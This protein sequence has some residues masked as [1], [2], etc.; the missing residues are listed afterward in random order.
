[1]VAR[2]RQVCVQGCERSAGE[3]PMF[4]NPPYLGGESHR[5]AAMPHVREHESQGQRAEESRCRCDDPCRT[6]WHGY[7]HQDTPDDEHSR[8]RA[9]A[10]ERRLAVPERDHCDHPGHRVC[11]PHSRVGVSGDVAQFG[12]AV[13]VRCCCRRP[14]AAEHRMEEHL[15]RSNAYAQTPQRYGFSRQYRADCSRDEQRDRDT[16]KR[17]C[18]SA[19]QHVG[20]C[21]N[22]D[23]ERCGGPA[24][25]HSSPSRG[26]QTRCIRHRYPFSLTQSG[27]GPQQPAM[28]RA[29]A[30]V[31]GVH[32]CVAGSG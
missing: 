27:L 19:G 17:R 10:P 26:R 4:V 12:S 7:C 24:A 11:P 14:H 5:W 29:D 22:R 30:R 13:D 21:S 31:T 2:G 9:D 20:C 32:G 1:M 28:R 25:R 23:R 3:C 8:R 6:G 15:T 16:E 18:R